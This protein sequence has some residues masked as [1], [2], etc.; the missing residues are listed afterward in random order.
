MKKIVDLL[1]GIVIGIAN[2]IPG[3]SGGTMAVILG[4]YER[5]IDA[6]GQITKTPLK[7][8]KDVWLL[9]IGVVVGVIISSFTIIY[10]LNAFPFPTILLFVG[11]IIGSIPMIYKNIGLT[12][13]DN[14]VEYFKC[15]IA[16]LVFL[17]LVIILPFIKKGN[18]VEDI[19]FVNV[20]VIFFM[21]IISA[22]AMIVPGISGSLVLMIFGY[23]VLILTDLKNL[24]ASFLHFDFSGFGLNLLVILVFLVGCI[25]GFLLLSK[26]IKYL[27]TRWPKIVYSAIVGLLVASIFSIIYTCINDYSEKIDFTSPYL[28]IFST[29]TL[30]MGILAS[31]FMAKYKGKEKDENN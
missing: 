15:I 22:G 23:Y 31:Y 4:V 26:L 11:L 24:I 5:I 28:Y 27:L 6:V 30:I 8:I 12:K 20:V 9:V 1:K 13:E 3:F 16:F 19:N 14:K 10:A 2:I 25:L 17:A 18:A 7:V 29:L 21:G